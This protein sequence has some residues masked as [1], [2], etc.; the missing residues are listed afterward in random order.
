MFCS[1]SEFARKKIQGGEREE[2][3]KKGD[4]VQPRTE[5]RCLERRNPRKGSL[6][7]EGGGGFKLEWEQAQRKQGGVNIKKHGQDL[8]QKH[9]FPEILRKEREGKKKEGKRK[10]S[11]RGAG[12][13]YCRTVEE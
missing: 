6:G 8:I 5:G 13:W 10:E 11:E 7:V 2:E 12:N 3:G 1:L 4:L 9:R